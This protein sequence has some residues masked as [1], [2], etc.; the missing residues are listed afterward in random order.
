MNIV[1]QASLFGDPPVV[2]G[3]IVDRLKAILAE[4][5]EARDSYQAA[6]ALYW[7]E[8]DGLDAAL[9]KAL[10]QTLPEP[11]AGDLCEDLVDAFQEWFVRFATSPK[12]LQNRAMELQRQ[13]PDLDATPDTRAWRD[14]QARA[15]PVK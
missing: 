3:N 12:T 1:M 13:D 8:F 9:R 14:K 5:P 7:V 15:G 11:Q 10:A 2:A 6:M 4:H